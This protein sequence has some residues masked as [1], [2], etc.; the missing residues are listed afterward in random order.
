VWFTEAQ[1]AGHI[2]REYR[3]GEVTLGK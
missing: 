1:L 3:P 2:E